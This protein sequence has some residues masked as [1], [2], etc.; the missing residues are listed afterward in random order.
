MSELFTNFLKHKRNR[1]IWKSIKFEKGL[2]EQFPRISTTNFVVLFSSENFK[3]ENGNFRKY[4]A[5]F[6]YFVW[7]HDLSLYK[8]ACLHEWI[9]IQDSRFMYA[10][11][12]HRCQL[13]AQPYLGSF[14]YKILNNI[15]Y[16]N[17]KLHT[18]GLSNTQLCSF[19]NMK[20]ET[21]SHLFYYCI[22]IQDIWNQVQIYFTDCFHFSQLTPQTAIFG[23]HNIDNDTFLIQ[24]HILLI[25][26]IYIQ[27]QKTRIFIF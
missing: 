15:L 4:H 16:L 20:E 8:K 9:K 23:F 25:Q 10:W 6:F 7:Y 3:R 22:Y 1:N 26:I 2:L 5:Y 24:N 21:I 19:C 17:K 18:F 14:Q 27:C 12:L 11:I 13:L